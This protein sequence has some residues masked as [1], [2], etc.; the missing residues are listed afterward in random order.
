MAAL[1]WQSQIGT[2]EGREGRKETVF[3]MAASGAAAGFSL[4]QGTKALSFDCLLKPAPN[5]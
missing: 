3:V 4:L 1:G 2:S 5:P